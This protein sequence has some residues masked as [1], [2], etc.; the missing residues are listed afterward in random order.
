MAIG[1]QNGALSHMYTIPAPKKTEN[2]RVQ[3]AS[4]PPSGTERSNDMKQNI[5]ALPQRGTIALPRRGTRPT[6]AV[7]RIKAKLDP[8]T[9]ARAAGVLS[10]P[11][12][13]EGRR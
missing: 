11:E 10:E 2:L 1:G 4:G 3:S 7:D 13:K 8:L 9:M 12:R 5:T 6:T